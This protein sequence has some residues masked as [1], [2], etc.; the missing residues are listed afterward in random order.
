VNPKAFLFLM[1]YA[2]A[3]GAGLDQASG[4]FDLKE[5]RS[6]ALSRISVTFAT[7]Y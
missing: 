2:N 5:E 3:A 1:D 6:S 4:S 7:K